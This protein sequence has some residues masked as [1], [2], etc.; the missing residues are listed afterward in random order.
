MNSPIATLKDYSLSLLYIIALII[1]MSGCV[2]IDSTLLTGGKIGPSEACPNLS[3]PPPQYEEVVDIA[4]TDYPPSDAE[5]KNKRTKVL[6]L[7]ASDKSMKGNRVYKNISDY[8]NVREKMSKG[9]DILIAKVG[10][11]VIDSESKYALATYNNSS[12]MRTKEYENM[13][14]QIKFIAFPSINSV[15]F[16][17]KF[18]PKCSFVT[19]KGT[20]KKPACIYEASF[21]GTVML[22]NLRTGKEYNM[23]VTGNGSLTNKTLTGHCE[24]TG[25]TKDTIKVIESAIDSSLDDLS[26]GDVFSPDLYITDKKVNKEKNDAIFEINGGVSTGVRKGQLVKVCTIRDKINKLTGKTSREKSLLASGKVT[27]FVKEE[28]AWISI[29]EDEARDIRLGDIVTLEKKKGFLG[30]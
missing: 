16:G 15:T 11:Q 4:F 9:L 23:P 28:S 12:F 25:S 13:I 10:A 7:P 24:K 20:K 5:L 8:V 14:K 19:F 29:P 3:D 27:E 21:R 2:D 22:R 6:I 18:N 26:F 17:S 1:T 30:Y